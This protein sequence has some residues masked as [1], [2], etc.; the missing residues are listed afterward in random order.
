MLAPALA[1]PLVI[2]CNWRMLKM[3]K[4]FTCAFANWWDSLNQRTAPRFARMV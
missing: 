4:A 3:L 1:L 2:G